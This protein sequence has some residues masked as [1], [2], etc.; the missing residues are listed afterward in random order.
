[1]ESA[2]ETHV[3]TIESSP[4]ANARISGK[5]QDARRTS[6]TACATREGAGSSGRVTQAY[7]LPRTAR[8]RDSKAIQAF[9]ASGRVLRGHWFIVRQAA[10]SAG[11][12]RLV[13]R[14]ANK[15]VRAAVARNRIRRVIRETF[16][17]LRLELPAL[18]Y[19]I[20]VRADLTQTTAAD[21]R[22]ELKR[23]LRQAK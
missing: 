7:R 13:M 10:N 2:D 8:L 17:V 22:Q 6:G 12:S 4:P 3:S 23:L 9:S 18:D 1:M 11:Y 15:T 20:V 14:V 19:L 16:R 5:A 21:M